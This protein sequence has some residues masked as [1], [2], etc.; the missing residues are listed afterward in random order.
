MS[1][2]SQ[3]AVQN[4]LDEVKEAAEKLTKRRLEE[5]GL[6]MH[7]EKEDWVNNT[8]GVTESTPVSQARIA[9]PAEPDFAPAGIPAE[10]VAKKDQSSVVKSDVGTTLKSSSKK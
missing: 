10:D 5:D 8:E 3:D 2:R 7:Q 4:Q 6:D 9:N 1:L